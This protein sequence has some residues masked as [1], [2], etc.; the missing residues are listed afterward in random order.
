MVVKYLRYTMAIFSRIKDNELMIGTPFHDYCTENFALT[1]LVYWRICWLSSIKPV[2]L[3]PI[4]TSQ[5]VMKTT[6]NQGA[7]E[8]R[9]G[10][11]VENLEAMA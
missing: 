9:V 6:A 5:S 4:S 7:K 1:H 10:Q 11:V 8:Q 2:V 3:S